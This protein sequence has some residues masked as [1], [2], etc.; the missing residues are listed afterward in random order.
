[1]P[2]VAAPK[3]P[4][5]KAKSEWAAKLDELL[6]AGVQVGSEAGIAIAVDGAHMAAPVHRH[7]V[8]L[9]VIDDGVEALTRI[10]G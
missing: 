1:M 7:V 3:T 5:E 10:H 9:A 8:G 6:A 2:V 4:K